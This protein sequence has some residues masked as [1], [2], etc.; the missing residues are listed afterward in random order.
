[1]GCE[2]KGSP[3]WFFCRKIFFEQMI[4]HSIQNQTLIL[5]LKGF[6]IKIKSDRII[7]GQTLKKS[8]T[9]GGKTKG[10]YTDSRGFGWFFHVFGSIFQGITRTRTR[11]WKWA[12]D[13]DS[14]HR[15]TPNPLWFCYLIFYKVHTLFIIMEKTNLNYWEVF[16][17]ASIVRIINR[18]KNWID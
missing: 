17:V 18:I 7:F 12:S 14:P 10:F 4:H 2:T 3:L 11:I 13:S 6:H 16:W 15:L 9:K 8:K 5:N 1:M